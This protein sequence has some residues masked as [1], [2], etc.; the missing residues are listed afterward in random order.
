MDSTIIIRRNP[1]VVYRELAE[2]D[3]AVLLHLDTA[4]YHGLNPTAAAVWELLDDGVSFAV[5]IDVLRTHVESTPSALE[6]EI[7]AFLRQLQERDLLY[8]GEGPG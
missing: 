5:L 3:G 8:L 7:A 6:P 1:R 4:A 2:G